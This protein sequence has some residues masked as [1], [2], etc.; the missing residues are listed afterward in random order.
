MRWPDGN[1]SLNRQKK[2]DEKR[3]GAMMLINNPSYLAPLLTGSG[4]LDFP[5]FQEGN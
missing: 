1:S 2:I 5:F 4:G 3:G